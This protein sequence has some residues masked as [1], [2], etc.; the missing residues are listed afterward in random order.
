MNK[1]LNGS[2]KQKSAQIIV[3]RRNDK[4]WLR[5]T[6]ISRTWRSWKLFNLV[7]PSIKIELLFTFILAIKCENSWENQIHNVR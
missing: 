4:K 5:K 7:K 3:T 6:Y 1:K 2:K